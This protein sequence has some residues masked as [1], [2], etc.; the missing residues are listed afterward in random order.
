MPTP[1]KRYRNR[2]LYNTEIKRY[3]TLEDVGKLIRGGS[4]IVVTDSVSGEDVTAH[5]LTQ[6]IMGQE[7]KGQGI[8]SHGLLMEL[9]KARLDTLAAVKLLLQGSADWDGWLSS[10]GIPTR[11]DVEKLSKE[12]DNLSLAIDVV[13]QKEKESGGE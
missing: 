5:I 9:I 10:I 4:E 13:G 6:V 8:F 2:K 1:I 12:I 3:I 11:Q 7:K